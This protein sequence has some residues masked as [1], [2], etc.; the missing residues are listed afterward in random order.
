MLSGNGE[1]IAML[2]NAL[3]E[4]LG[5]IAPAFIAICVFLFAFSSI[6]GSYY[7]G[8]TNIEF[9]KNSPAAVFGFRIATMA[10][11]FIGSVL[12]LGMVWSFAD[13]FMAGMTLINLTAISLLGGIALKVIND[14]QEQR[15][16]G[17]DPVFSAKALGIENT[18]C[19]DEEETVRPAAGE[20]SPPPIAR[21]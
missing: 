8:E 1:G 17:L 7:Y 9:I 20:A 15:K 19:W 4:Q 12:S 11:V 10:F 2:Q 5:A 18:E 21:R 16:K 6:V 3:G 13:L 14:Y